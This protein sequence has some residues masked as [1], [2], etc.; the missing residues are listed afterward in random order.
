MTTCQNNGTM[1]RTQF[2]CFTRVTFY[3]FI[4]VRTSNITSKTHSTL[5]N[6][7]SIGKSED[8][9][10]TRPC[11][12]A[13]YFPYVDSRIDRTTVIVINIIIIIVKD[14]LNK[15]VKMWLS[16][17]V[18]WSCIKCAH[19]WLVCMD[20]SSCHIAPATSTTHFQIPLITLGVVMVTCY[21]SHIILPRRENNTRIQ[22]TYT[23]VSNNT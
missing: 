15:A 19:I 12:H 23:G 17:S 20:V 8:I 13:S 10:E 6:A 9:A 14:Q 1:H 18:V 21:A 5:Y 22:N 2:P 16:M 7:S 11:V 3:C 4:F